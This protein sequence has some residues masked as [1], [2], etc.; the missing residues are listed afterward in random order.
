MGDDANV[1]PE[2]FGGT[3]LCQEFS[4]SQHHIAIPIEDLSASLE[5]VKE[6]KPATDSYVDNN[7]NPEENDEETEE[8]G[9]CRYCQQEDF[10]SKLESPCNCNGSVK[11]Y[12]PD[13]YSVPDLPS[14]DDD[15][16]ITIRQVIYVDLFFF[17]C[18]FEEW[19]IPGTNTQIRSPLV[20]AECATNDLINSMNKDFNLRNPTGG[21]IFGAAILIF[22]AVLLIKDAYMSTTPEEDKFARILYCV[23]YDVY[24]CAGLRYIVGFTMPKVIETEKREERDGGA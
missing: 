12:N 6:E 23:S 9:E 10:V 1:L 7:Q 13:Y 16:E 4:I 21:V 11:P 20:V 22:I 14:D 3:R 24:L 19:S 2:K 5:A 17:K 15:T 8:K 18:A